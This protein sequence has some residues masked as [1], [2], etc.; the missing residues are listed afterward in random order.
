MISSFVVG[1]VSDWHEVEE[2]CRVPVVKELWVATDEV[3]ADQDIENSAD[4]CDFLSRSYHLGIIPVSSKLVNIFTHPL[5]VAIQLLICS[6]DSFSP[7]LDN[8]FLCIASSSLQRISL[9]A[10][11]FCLG[12]YVPLDPLQSLRKSKVVQKIE[13]RKSV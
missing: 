4:E 12:R 11:L 5:P 6:G 9:P 7:F 8:A 3:S 10:N 13:N 2:L 1:V